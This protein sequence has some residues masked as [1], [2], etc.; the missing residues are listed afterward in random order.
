LLTIYLYFVEKVL[1]VK[2]GGGVM[3]VVEIQT[4]DHQRRF[5]VIDDEGNLI[6]PIVQ[7]LKYLDRIGSARNTLCTYA[8]A[9]RLYWQYLGQEGID[10]QQITLDDLARFV[11]WLKVPSGSLKVLPA[12]PVE[13]ARSNRTI[14]QTLSVVRS[15]YD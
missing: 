1:R 5:V 3:R 7:Y 13:Q 9:L 11:L 4:Q 6:E 14:N 8:I 12:R 2:E 10:W 15:F